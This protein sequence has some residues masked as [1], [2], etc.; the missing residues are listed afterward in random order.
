[1]TILGAALTFI[2]MTLTRDVDV[3]TQKVVAFRD[4]HGKKQVVW[5]EFQVP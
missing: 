5:C 4:L 3:S 1:V 2:K